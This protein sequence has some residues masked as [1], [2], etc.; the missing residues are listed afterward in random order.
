MN[1]NS[2]KKFV[3]IGMY[4]FVFLPDFKEMKPT[5]LKL[6]VENGLLGIILLATEGLNGT[7]SGERTG[8]DAL[9]SYLQSDARFQNLRYKES[10]SDKPLFRRIRVRLKREIVTMGVPDTDPTHLC[11]KR[12]D[13]KKWNELLEDASVITIDTRNTYEYDVGTFKNAISPNTERFRD[14]PKFVDTEL[15]RQKNQRIAMFCTGGI[16][17]EKATNYLIK[18]GFKD[19]YHLDGG[20]LKYLETVDKKESLWRGECYVFDGRVTVDSNLAS[21]SYVQCLACRRPLSEAD[22]QSP[23]YEI[24]VSCHH[25]HGKFTAKKIVSL[26]ERQRQYELAARRKMTSSDKPVIASKLVAKTMLS[27]VKEYPPVSNPVGVS[28]AWNFVF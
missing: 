16:R 20:I 22:C 25:C 12:V 27:K 21:G 17:C 13:A 10:F 18:K 3:I 8:V 23:L 14:F 19:V 26:K 4:Q 9:L 2:K 1:K 28:E 15:D 24:G 6:C 11:G 5:I 7:V